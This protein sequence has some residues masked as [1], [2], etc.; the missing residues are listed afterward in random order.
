MSFSNRNLNRIK[1]NSLFWG[2]KAHRQKLAT[3]IPFNI[4]GNFLHPT[5]TVRNLRVWFNVDF[6]FS[7]HVQKICIAFFLLKHNLRGIRQYLTYEVAVLAANSLVCSRLD[8]CNSLFISLSSF[9]FHRLQSIPNILSHP[10]STNS[11]GCLL[12][13]TACSKLLRWST[14]YSTVAPLAILDHSCL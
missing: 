1:L 13:T 10:S 11:T 3:Y 12:I 7:E 9:N 14:N 2:F 5:E 8:Y 6:S 4:H